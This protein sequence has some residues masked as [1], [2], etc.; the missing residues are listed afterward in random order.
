MGFAKSVCHVIHLIGFSFILGN[1]IMDNVFGKR[2]LQSNQYSTI[3]WL[4]LGAWLSLIVTGTANIMLFIIEYRYKYTKAFSTWIKCLLMKAIITII[5]AFFIE[6]I[7][8][9]FVHGAQKKAVV[10][11]VR[12]VLFFI[13]FFLSHFTREMREN[14]LIPTINKNMPIDQQTKGKTE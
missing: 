2:Q 5:M 7:I 3:G 1:M 4:Y 8:G 11:I 13:T 6:Y 14:K 9:L 12:I 10:N